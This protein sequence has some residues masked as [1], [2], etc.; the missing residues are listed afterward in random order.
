MDQRPVDC[1]RDRN[2]N[3]N[4]SN[5]H[6][7]GWPNLVLSLDQSRRGYLPA[8][9]TTAILAY[10]HVLTIHPAILAQ[11]YNPRIF[12]DS[13]LHTLAC[14]L[15]HTRY[16]YPRFRYILPSHPSHTTTHG[17]N[18]KLNFPPTS[19]IEE[20]KKNKPKYIQHCINT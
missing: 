16:Y 7:H 20:E 2:P 5:G 19:A 17:T 8:D 12:I 15:T 3:S 18:A 1:G 13:W 10:F 4:S 14:L 11:Q 6:S 9:P